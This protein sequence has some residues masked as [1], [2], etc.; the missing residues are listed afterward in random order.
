[1]ALSLVPL[2][3]LD[4]AWLE[5]EGDSPEADHPAYMLL[6][7]FKEYFIST[8]LENETVYPR[9]LWNHHRLAKPV[10]AFAEQ[11]I[12]ENYYWSPTVLHTFTYITGTPDL[13]QPTTLKVGITP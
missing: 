9:Q 6:N 11:R 12:S 5:V 4:D 2:D 1:M 8:W 13:V 7:E 10:L 3:K